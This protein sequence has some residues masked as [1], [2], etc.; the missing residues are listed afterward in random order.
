MTRHAPAA[1]ILLVEDNPVDIDLT[2]RAFRKKRLDSPIE[3]A[4]D[5]RRPWRTWIGGRPGTVRR[6]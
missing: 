6:R 3:L 1:S 2:L 5:G 4:R